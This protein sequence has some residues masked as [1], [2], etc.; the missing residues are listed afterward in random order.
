[1]L[2]GSLMTPRVETAGATFVD[3]VPH[4]VRWRAEK[5]MARSNA[6]GH[7]TAMQHQKSLRDRAVV[8]LPRDAMGIPSY[9]R[10]TAAERDEP[11][12]IG[13]SITC[14]DP[15]AAHRLGLYTSPESSLNRENRPSTA[16]RET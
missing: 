16:N 11:V 8:Y 15:A 3:H 10:T 14:P 1:M 5:E 6:R 13:E 12:L 7:I 4:I 9:V 2:L